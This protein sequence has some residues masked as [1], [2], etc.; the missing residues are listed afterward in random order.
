MTR[1]SVCGRIP[2]RVL[3]SV[4]TIALCVC[5][6]SVHDAQAKEEASIIDRM[7]VLGNPTDRGGLISLDPQ[8]P[9]SSV[10]DS[11]GLL[12]RVPGG[13]LVFNGAL[14][15]QAQ[16]R[17]LFGIRLN[18]RIN[19]QAI[20]P[21]GPNLMDPPLHY[22]PKQLLETLDVTRGIASVSSGPG[23]GGLIEA[24]L[25]TSRF[26][27]T[28]RFEVGGELVAN[29]QTVDEGGGG[30]GIVSLANN[31]HR[32]HVLG[33]FESGDDIDFAG[34]TIL[35]T[36]YER[37]AVAGG[38]GIKL[39]NH[40]ISFDYR[41]HETAPSGNPT[42]PLD[43]Q[44][45]ESD[46]FDLNYRGAWGRF[47]VEA[48]VSYSDVAHSMD[49]QSIRPLPAGVPVI[50]TPATG[51]AFNYAASAHH[52][53]FGGRISFGV[54]GQLA[55]NS[56]TVTQP[57]NPGFF[58]ETFNDAETNRYGG[59]VEWK[60]PVARRTNFELGVRYDRVETNADPVSAGATPPVP[61]PVQM[62]VGMFNA[63]DRERTD[64]NVDAL[65]RLEHQIGT[66]WTVSATA[67]R[68]TRSPFWVERYAFLPIEVTAG[69]ADGNNTIGDVDLEPEKGALFE[70]GFDYSRN[71]SFLSVRGFFHRIDDYIQSTPFDDTLTTLEDGID[72]EA[73]IPNPLTPA[74]GPAFFAQF[75]GP[76]GVAPD[77]P[78]EIVSIVNG[79]ATPLQFSNV[80]A[81]LF[82]VDAAFGT[83]IAEN[84]VNPNDALLFDGI[85]TYVQGARRDINDDLYRITPLRSTLVMTYR[86]PTWSLSVEGVLVAEQERISLTNGELPTDGFQLLNIYGQWAPNRGVLRGLQIAAGVEN[87]VNSFYQDH[88]AGFNRVPFSD[89]PLFRTNPFEG[90][91]PESRLPGAGVGGFVQ[92]S[93]RF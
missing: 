26:G 19:G 37:W 67:A 74:G 1:L 6:V 14:S 78:Q 66:S 25:K 60:G 79:D 61:G 27:T 89:V 90:L 73:A 48:S 49:N 21:G 45:F 93:Y 50:E 15:G 83:R 87:V 32:F 85:V 22:A 71:S 52:A 20:N 64:N 65:A 56:A 68:K 10:A 77:S 2:A 86:R 8:L 41:R 72:P 53:L 34:G 47:D 3:S 28:D 55:T 11:A 75:D 54:D 91:D 40:E 24:N 43:I 59:F 29:G 51:E 36:E 58:I 81:R 33:N 30:G 82:G 62:L 7:T 46:F 57:L 70:A 5:G 35:G 18:T 42:F 23:I 39:G 38:Y 76:G 31:R 12:R 16:L 9:G 13:A 69:L 92:V 88:L 84:L 63:L 17:G 44:F 80:D 4:S